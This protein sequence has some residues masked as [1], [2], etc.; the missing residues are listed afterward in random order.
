M[1]IDINYCIIWFKLHKS[2]FDVEVGNNGKKL[3]EYVIICSHTLN[4]N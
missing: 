3:I 2:D 4:V 1:A